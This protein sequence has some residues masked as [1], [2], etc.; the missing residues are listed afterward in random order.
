MGDPSR[1]LVLVFSS[2]LSENVVFCFLK[3]LARYNLNNAEVRPMIVTPVAENT[4]RLM[5]CRS[6]GTQHNCFL[7]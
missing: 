6:T 3:D 4:L 2:G 1:F 5:H 7:G